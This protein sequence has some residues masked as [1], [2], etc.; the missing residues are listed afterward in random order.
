M[1][2]LAFLANNTLGANLTCLIP[3]VVLGWWRL[4]CVRPA[5][6]GR[7]EIPSE[8]F[9]IIPSGVCA[10]VVIPT[11][12]LMY[13]LPIS[14]MVA[15][16]IMRASVIVIGR[17]VDEVQIR[18]G[19]LG[20]RVYWEENAAVLFAVGAA[21]IELTGRSR[22]VMAMRFWASCSFFVTS[23]GA[24]ESASGCL[25]TAPRLASENVSSSSLISRKAV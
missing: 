18:Q 10:A 9:Y 21:S 25:G 4:K 8:L 12:T 16:V 11:T 17:V 3:A 2:E 14:V 5:R 7:W 20:K 1:G 22:S 6:L 15:M 19:I 24:I 13:T 23:V